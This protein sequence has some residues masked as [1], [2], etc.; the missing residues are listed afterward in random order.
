MKFGDRDC[1][2][3]YTSIVSMDY[4]LIYFHTPC[5]LLANRWCL[6]KNCIWYLLYTLR[7]VWNLNKNQV[8]S[9]LN[10][11]KYQWLQKNYWIFFLP[12]VLFVFLKNHLKLARFEKQLLYLAQDI[13]TT[14]SELYIYHFF[15]L[16]TICFNRATVG[17]FW[18]KQIFGLLEVV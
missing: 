5:S 12:C 16:F 1:P 11:L 9:P 18:E 10:I 14:N 2:N 3:R 17:I 15:C 13:P 6:S 7:F 4:I 8:F